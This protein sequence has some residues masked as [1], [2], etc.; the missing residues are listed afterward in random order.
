VV[1]GEARV[2]KPPPAYSS[3]RL[4]Y[5]HYAYR[6]YYCVARHSGFD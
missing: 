3:L 1:A 4:A 2:A 6:P 5:S